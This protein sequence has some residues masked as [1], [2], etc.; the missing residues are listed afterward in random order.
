MSM[1]A[2]KIRFRNASCLFRCILLSIR[3]LI[4]SGIIPSA[5]SG[6]TL[7]RFTLVLSIHVYVHMIIS[8]SNRFNN[9]N[10]LRQLSIYVMTINVV[11]NLCGYILLVLLY[12]HSI[13]TIFNRKIPVLQRDTSGCILP[14]PHPAIKSFNTHL[15]LLRPLEI[16]FRFATA[17]FR[18]LPD[19][20]ILGET[21]CGTTN[22]CGHIVSVAEASSSSSPPSSSL[23]REINERRIVRIKCYT[24]FCPWAFPELDHKESFYFVGHYLGI[25]DPYFYRMAFPLKITRWWEERV[26]G[27][28]F[29]C[30]DGCAQYLTSPSAAYLIASAYQNEEISG[31]RVCIAPSLVACVRNPVEQAV[32]WWKYENNACSWGESMGLTEWN[33]CLRSNDYPPKSI[34]DAL[35]YSQSHFVRAAYADAEHL[36]KTLIK[37]QKRNNPLYYRVKRLPNWAITWPGGQ[38]ATIGRSGKYTGNINRYNNVFYSIFGEKV[39]DSLRRKPRT[40]FVHIV[41]IEDQS[42]GQLLKAALRPIFA[43]CMTRSAHRGKKHSYYADLM[44]SVEW[45]VEKYVHNFNT[46][47]RNSGRSLANMDLE[48]SCSDIDE[49]HKYFESDMIEFEQLRK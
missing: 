16:L 41:P 49:L 44:A 17:P 28:I 24:P 29:L 2:F 32:S 4:F 25:V 22:L 20:I 37:Q 31:S 21:R 13:Q 27:N 15:S 30:F 40:G 43:D 45:A 12:R 39:E 14:E 33:T 38:L 8:N 35:K 7:P 6:R 9:N 47:R 48:P 11:L 46:S 42:C 3:E 5:R 10:S 34:G 18:V 26:L 19:I 36:A 1:A 23:S